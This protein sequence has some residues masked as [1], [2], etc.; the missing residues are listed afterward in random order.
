MK[1]LHGDAPDGESFN[2]KELSEESED[3]TTEGKA[4]PAPGLPISEEEYKRMKEKAKH[5][6]A[7]RV[8]EAQEDRP[9]KKGKS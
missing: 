6:P 2:P 9:K 7:P 3:A 8:R 4:A 5:A 1:P